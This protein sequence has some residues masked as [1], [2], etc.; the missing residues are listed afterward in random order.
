MSAYN[1]TDG[2]ASTWFSDSDCFNRAQ[3]GD[4]EALSQIY[5]GMSR[6]MYTVLRKWKIAPELAEDVVHEG[7]VRF[8]S[9]ITS[10]DRTREGGSSKKWFMTVAKN[11][12]LQELRTDRRFA[13]KFG[14]RVDS[15]LLDS[16]A[17]RTGSPDDSAQAQHL[18]ND[19][20]NTEVLHKVVSKTRRDVWQTFLRMYV[21]GIT[22][23]QAAEEFGISPHTATVR[24][25]RVL[26]RLREA[27]LKLNLP[28]DEPK[29]SGEDSSV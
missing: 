11:C 7:M 18:L 24:K 23:N 27:G 22:E 9:K 16:V 2:Q 19:L 12:L 4:R 29:S 1:F 5:R 28:T 13:E 21:D 3:Q 20:F 10:I 14:R 26:K 8:L 15:Q 25:R 6:W 17:A